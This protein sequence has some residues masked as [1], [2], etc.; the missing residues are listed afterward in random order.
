MLGLEVKIF[1]FGLDLGLAA[2]GLGL[3][4]VTPGMSFR[5]DCL[6]TRM[7]SI[8]NTPFEYRS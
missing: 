6:Q 2:R 1:S 7:S 3:G 4:L 5:V 8:P